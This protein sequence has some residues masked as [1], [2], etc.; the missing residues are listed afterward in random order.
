M[1]RKGVVAQER[2]ANALDIIARNAQPQAQLVDDLLQVSQITAGTLRLNRSVVT[3]IPIAEAALESLRPVAEAKRVDLVVDMPAE[4][5]PIY[6]D[7]TR[8]QQIVSNVLANAIKFTPEGGQVFLHLTRDAG[9][10]V[11]RVRD[12]GIGIAQE[13][14][15]HVFEPFRQADSSTTRSHSG[16]G[17]G[18]AIV[19]RLVEMHD[20]TIDAQSD[21]PNQGALFTVRLPLE[22]AASNASFSGVAGPAATDSETSL[23][24]QR[25]GIA[26][27]SIEAVR[28]ERVVPLPAV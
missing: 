19:R 28:P 1:L 3:L 26:E 20:G 2:R 16:V 17:L 15:P 13:F 24:H 14:L 8:V 23:P 12:T 22:D 6:A 18:L 27:I 5:L 9:H 11:I 10:V 7:A 25:V 21:G 4:Q